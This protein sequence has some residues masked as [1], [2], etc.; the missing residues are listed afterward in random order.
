M[1]FLH[2]KML[3]IRVCVRVCVECCA[4]LQY[5]INRMLSIK[6]QNNNKLTVG[7]RGREG[8]EER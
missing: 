1:P 4:P 7:E 8:E 3:Q 2:A 6:C 5:F